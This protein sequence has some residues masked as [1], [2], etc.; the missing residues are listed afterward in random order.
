M[1]FS[2]CRFGEGGFL[3]DKTLMDVWDNTCK[4]IGD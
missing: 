4:H 2:L 1:H 3:G